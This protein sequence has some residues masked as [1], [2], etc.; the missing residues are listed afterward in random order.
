MD[1]A[2]R[3][4]DVMKRILIVEDI[5]ETQQW[6][7]NAAQKAFSD[8]II[9]LSAS[10]AEAK[11]AIAQQQ[12]DLML[13]DLNLP[14]GN[15][16]DLVAEMSSLETPPMCVIVTI[17][18]DDQHVFP[19]LEAGADGYLLKD[20]PTEK[21]ARLLKGIVNGEPPLSPSIARKILKVFK[22]KVTS[23]AH[24]KLTARETE[25]LILIAKGYSVPKVAEMLNISPYTGS[26]HVKNVY[27]KLNISSRA[28]AALAA[29]QM[30]IL[31]D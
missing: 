17:Y 8:A 1:G 4:A 13:I 25:V 15:G 18:D 23:P 11:A 9:R 27:R 14:D 5:P 29:A 28:E 30:G 24:P 22:E 21:I 12:P 16:Q 19:S 20:Q 3:E 2:L 31:D 26:D 6:L 10:I 7:Q